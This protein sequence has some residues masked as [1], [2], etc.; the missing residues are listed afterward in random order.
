MNISGSFVVE[1]TLLH[2][3]DAIGILEINQKIGFT[4]ESESDIL[5]IEVPQA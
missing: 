4:A 2:T 1:D 5:L 3:R